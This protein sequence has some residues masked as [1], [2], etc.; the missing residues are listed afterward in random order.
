V[1][2][3]LATKLLKSGAIVIEVIAA[4]FD[5]KPLT[6]SAYAAVAL[7]SLTPS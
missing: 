7:F 3:E 1:K 4:V 5:H 2:V 6:K